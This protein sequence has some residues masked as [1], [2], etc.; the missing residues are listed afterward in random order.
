MAQAST[1][2]QTKGHVPTLY[3]NIPNYKRTIERGRGERG[4]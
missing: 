4:V 1:Q 3:Y 2:M